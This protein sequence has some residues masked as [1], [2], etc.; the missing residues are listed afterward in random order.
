VGSADRNPYVQIGIN[1]ASEN[2]QR[3]SGSTEICLDGWAQIFRIRV[4]EIR[5][6]ILRV[7]I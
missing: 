2:V 4:K 5:T 6:P 7:K 3:K 1:D